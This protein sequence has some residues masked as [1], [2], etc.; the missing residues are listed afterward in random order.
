MEHTVEPTSL[1]STYFKDYYQRNKERIRVRNASS[2]KRKAYVKAYRR[3]KVAKDTNRRWA[4]KNPEQYA[5]IRQRA[6][7]KFRLK[8]F[9]LTPERYQEMIEAQQHCCAICKSPNPGFT[10][11]GRHGPKPGTNPWPTT[12]LAS[13]RIVWCVDHDHET[14]AVRGLLCHSCNR[15]LGSVK[16]S[17]AVLRSMI[18]YLNKE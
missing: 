13:N 5:E 3:T 1:R 8:R 4:D 18:V 16:D 6:L 17:V 2:E 14:K 9:G 7:F 10:R 11:N 12:R 15:A